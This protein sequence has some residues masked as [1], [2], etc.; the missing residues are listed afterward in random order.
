MLVVEFLCDHQGSV[1]RENEIMQ[2]LLLGHI[3][4]WEM[5]ESSGSMH[6]EF[7]RFVYHLSYVDRTYFLIRPCCH[8]E[9]ASCS[10]SD[11]DSDLKRFVDEDNHT[12]LAGIRACK[13]VGSCE[14]A[15]SLL[16]ACEARWATGPLLRDIRGGGSEGQWAKYEWRDMLVRTRLSR[17]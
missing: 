1:R 14:T 17:R 8:Q 7:I 11:S 5:V 12:V 16:A 4:K 2:E 6:R 9:S 10:D 13:A 3:S 15:M